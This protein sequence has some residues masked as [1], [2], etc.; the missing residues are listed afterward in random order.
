MTDEDP[1]IHAYIWFGVSYFPYDIVMMYVGY[2]Y[3]ESW[4]KYH[5]PHSKSFMRFFRREPVLVLHHIIFLCFGLPVSE[6]SITM[7]SIDML[8]VC[9]WFLYCQLY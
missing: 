2:T 8:G 1:Y 9:N 3:H 5:K 6:V 4:Q 7:Y